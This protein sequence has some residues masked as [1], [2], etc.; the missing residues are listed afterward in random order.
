MLVKS[1]NAYGEETVRTVNHAG[2]MSVEEWVRRNYSP[3]RLG[4]EPGS[5]D[6]TIRSCEEDVRR[7]GSTCISH[8]SS[9]SGMTSWYLSTQLGEG[10]SV[11]DRIR[12]RRA[13]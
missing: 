5:I 8:H 9:A 11:R 2:E 12:R 6:R 4:R 10:E 7:F 1:V 3:R 13:V